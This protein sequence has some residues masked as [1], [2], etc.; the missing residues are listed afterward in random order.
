M[1][2]ETRSQ[3]SNGTVSLAR[4]AAVLA[5]LAVTWPG[6]TATAQDAE[7]SPSLSDTRL[8]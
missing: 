8:V 4:V 7:S 1:I 2:D 3:F 5:A 6:V